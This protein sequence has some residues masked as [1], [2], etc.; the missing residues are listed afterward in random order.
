MQTLYVFS[1]GYNLA[2]KQVEY[3]SCMLV[4]YPHCV[5]AVAGVLQACNVRPYMF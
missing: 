5:A 3:S 2:I 4:L 1:V